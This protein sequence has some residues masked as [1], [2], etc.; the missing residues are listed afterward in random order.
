VN[1]RWISC[2]KRRQGRMKSKEYIYLLST[3][4]KDKK[5]KT[6][7]SCDNFRC[8]RSSLPMRSR[9]HRWKAP[10]GGTVM[11]AH[12]NP[13]IH[14]RSIR[15]YDP[16]PITLAHA[17]RRRLLSL[18]ALGP[19]APRRLLFRGGCHRLSTILRAC[20]GTSPSRTTHET[21]DAPWLP[22]PSIA[23]PLPQLMS[24]PTRRGWRLWCVHC[25]APIHLLCAPSIPIYI[26]TLTAKVSTSRFLISLP[27]CPPDP[28]IPPQRDGIP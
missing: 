16:T 9:E 8:R 19:H 28:L 18:P 10:A 22:P 27:Y 15:S 21:F 24:T 13:T 3:T 7:V 1:I 11:P 17:Y 25:P 5:R 2:T 4:K 6:I 23:E 14:P 20:T 12:P 26:E